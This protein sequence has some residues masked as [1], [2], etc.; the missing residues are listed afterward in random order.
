MDRH[1]I[2]FWLIAILSIAAAGLGTVTAI[3]HFVASTPDWWVFAAEALVASGLAVF[4][5]AWR[6]RRA[7]R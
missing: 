4:A 6:R 7:S 2:A 3:S 5:I 1:N